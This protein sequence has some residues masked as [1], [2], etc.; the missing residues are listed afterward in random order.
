MYMIGSPDQWV[1]LFEALVHYWKLEISYIDTK[2]REQ[3][4]PYTLSNGAIQRTLKKS[5][6]NFYY[7]SCLSTYFTDLSSP[8][9]TDMKTAVLEKC[10]KARNITA[11]KNK[12]VI[13][14]KIDFYET[15]F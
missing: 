5:N 13:N 15:Q 8:C 3:G 14:K 11:D 7:A 4:F 9:L 10:N 6:N 2:S 1:W 12:N